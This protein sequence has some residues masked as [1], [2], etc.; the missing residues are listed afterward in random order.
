MGKVLDGQT[1]IRVPK[2]NLFGN[3][4]ALARRIQLPQHTVRI[5]ER[6]DGAPHHVFRHLIQHGEELAVRASW[7]L[8][9]VANNRSGEWV[10]PEPE[11]RCSTIEQR[12]HPRD[13]DVEY[14]PIARIR[15][16]HPTAALW[17]AKDL[18]A[19]LIRLL[20]GSALV[21]RLGGD[22]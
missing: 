14:R 3:L 15:D 11:R 20:G 21:V 19:D 12:G 4:S 16:P 8:C 6:D 2:I 9:D 5:T 1:D 7:Y 18:Y 13:L 22:G 17:L 10:G